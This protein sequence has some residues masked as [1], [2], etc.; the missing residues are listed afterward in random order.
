MCGLLRGELVSTTTSARATPQ[1]PPAPRALHRVS[2]GNHLAVRPRY[3]FKLTWRCSRIPPL[4]VG[5][6]LAAFAIRHFPYI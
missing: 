3:G 4:V 2:S 1:T 6:H 5:V